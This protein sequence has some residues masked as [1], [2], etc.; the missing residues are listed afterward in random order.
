VNDTKTIG[1]IYLVS[2]KVTPNRH[3]Q[4][5]CGVDNAFVIVIK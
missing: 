2:E 1:R 4:T 5:A 3:N